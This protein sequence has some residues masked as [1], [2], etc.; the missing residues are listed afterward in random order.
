ML[1]STRA[2]LN[3]LAINSI[4]CLLASGV[5]VFGCFKT[6]FVSPG[7]SDKLL[8]LV[9]GSSILFFVVTFSATV[10]DPDCSLPSS[11][12]RIS[13]EYLLIPGLGFLR[14]FLTSCLNSSLTTPSAS[15]KH[16]LRV[17]TLCS[18]DASSYNSKSSFT[19]FLCFIVSSLG[20]VPTALLL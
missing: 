18:G 7:D 13:S 12:F 8:L 2:S 15:S 14:S 10:K 5:C 20:I 6:S 17:A 19:S 4:N 16:S 11:T 9:C 3:P 1:E